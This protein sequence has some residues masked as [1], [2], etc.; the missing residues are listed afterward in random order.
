VQVNRT[1]KT[2]PQQVT[3]MFDN[4]KKYDALTNHDK[5]IVL[6][7]VGAQLSNKNKTPDS[8]AGDLLNLP[9]YLRAIAQD[10]YAEYLL[11]LSK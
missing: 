5:E 10:K 11:N 2:P 8:I 1:S 6:E 7:F 4:A 3:T 9:E